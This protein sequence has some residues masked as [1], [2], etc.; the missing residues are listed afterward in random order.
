MSVKF[1]ILLVVA[2]AFGASIG[3]VDSR[4]SWDDAGITVLAVLVVAAALGAAMPSRAWLWALVVGGCIVVM[5]AVL[6]HTYGA[7]LAFLPAFAGAYLGAV[8]RKSIHPS[9]SKNTH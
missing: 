6:N 5:N 8:V 3:W 2:L 7:A 1:W 9:N 4:P